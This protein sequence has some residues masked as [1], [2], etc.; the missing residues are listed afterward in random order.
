VKHPIGA[1]FKG[2]PHMDNPTSAIPAINNRLS[3]CDFIF[4]GAFR[5]ERPDKRGRKEDWACCAPPY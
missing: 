1:S 2:E 5:L 3:K 4:Q